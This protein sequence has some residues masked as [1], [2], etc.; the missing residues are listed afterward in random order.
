MGELSPKPLTLW[1]MA[2]PENKMR[3]LRGVRTALRFFNHPDGLA[4]AQEILD[5]F[6]EDGFAFLGLTEDEPGLTA[7]QETL[8]DFECGT[9]RDIDPVKWV[10]GMQARRMT[11]G[12]ATPEQVFQELAPGAP[13][14]VQKVQVKG[15]PSAKA[16]ETAIALLATCDGNSLKAAA[17]ARNLRHT[18]GDTALYT[19][20]IRAL[21]NALPWLEELARESGIEF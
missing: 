16:Y 5:T 9:A 4:D 19:N 14:T 10:R 8:A 7:L 11:Q 3:A 15:N 17:T 18:T 1:L 12:G 21:V 20:T 6:K 2:I 13:S